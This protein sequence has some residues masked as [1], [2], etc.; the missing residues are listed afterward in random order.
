M[1]TLTKKRKAAVSKFDAS[2]A[3]SRCRRI[4]DREGHHFNEIRRICGSRDPF[5]S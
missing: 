1:A 2:K 5:R 4:K 3:Y